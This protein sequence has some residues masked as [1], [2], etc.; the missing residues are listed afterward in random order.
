MTTPRCS[1]ARSTSTAL[2]SSMSAITAPPRRLRWR[3]M[4]VATWSLRLRAVWS[5]PPTG[6]MRAVRWCSTFMWTSSCSSLSSS[7]PALT[8]SSTPRRPS[9]MALP[10]SAVRIPCSV[11]MRAWASEPAT[12]SS[13]MA[14]STPTEALTRLTSSSVGSAKRPPHIVEPF[15]VVMARTVRPRAPPRPRRAAALPERDPPPSRRDLPLPDAAHAL[16]EPQRRGALLAVAQA[17]V[18]GEERRLVEL[19]VEERDVAPYRQRLQL[20]HQP[21]A[22]AVAPFLGA[23]RDALHAPPGLGRQPTHGGEHGA[24]HPLHE[25]RAAPRQPRPDL[26]GVLVRR[27]GGGVELGEARGVGGGGLPQPH[28][29]AGGAGLP[30]PDRGRGQLRSPRRP[31]RPLP[32]RPL[33]RR[34]S[35]PGRAAC[36]CVS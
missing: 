18:V 1:S 13:T 27:S 25:E 30:R 28:R 19:V 31:A 6:P 16:R 21:A 35:A 3:R 11:S 24:V 12:S 7:R 14:P 33:T 17:P 23:R 34:R 15:F 4:S 5:L 32:P 2:S 10:S 29:R 22:E 26:G 36:G 20:R 8:S 9:S